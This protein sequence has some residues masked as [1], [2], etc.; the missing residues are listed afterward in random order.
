MTYFAFLLRFLVVPIVFFVLVAWWD[1]RRGRS[2]PGFLDGRVVW[3]AIGLHVLLALVYTTPWDNYLVAT[4][5]WY[6]DP[7]LISGLLLGWVPVEEYLFFVLE[8]LLVG[9][10]WLFLARR[11]RQAGVFNPSRRIR[12]GSTAVLGLVWLSAVLALVSGW[13]PATYLALILGWALPAIGLQL[14]FGGDILWHHRRLVALAIL[15]LW[16]YLSAADSLAITAGT[17]TIDPRQTLGLHLGALP[18]EEAIF[19]LITVIIVSFGLTLALSHASQARWADLSAG[20]R[21]SPSPFPGRPGEGHP[22][23]KS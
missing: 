18:A 12:F 4:G 19:F 15:P 16:F 23:K 6:Y 10:W 21:S 9:L 7:S 3:L 5:V 20:L 13:K 17:W 1:A 14:F 8:T 11:A 2:T 22:V